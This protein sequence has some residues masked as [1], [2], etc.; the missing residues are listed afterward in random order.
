M[1]LGP[2]TP[3]GERARSPPDDQVEE[4][5]IL[6]QARADP[7]RFAPLYERY[8]A[9]LYHYCLRRLQR[10]EDGEDLAGLVFIRALAGLRE[11]GFTELT[12]TQRGWWRRPHQS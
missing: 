8:F 10:P 3:E 9:R 12:R 11:V 7:A 4:G 5:S 6:A 2:L 1:Q